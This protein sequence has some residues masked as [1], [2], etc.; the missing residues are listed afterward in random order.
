MRKGQPRSEVKAL[1]GFR[2]YFATCLETEGVN[3]VYVELL[4]GHDMGLKSAYSKPTSTQLLE[5]NGDKVLGYVH[6]INVLTIN[7]EDRLKLKV[8]RLTER[9]DEIM[10]IKD[11]HEKE[12]RCMRDEM[13]SRFKQIFTRI[14]SNKLST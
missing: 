11:K 10:R 5:G 9:E 12:M 7:E 14:D 6:G 3:P 13:E 4:L 8:K 1:H 2:K